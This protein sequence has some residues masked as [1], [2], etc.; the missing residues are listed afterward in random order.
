MIFAILC[1]IVYNNFITQK[2]WKILPFTVNF[3]RGGDYMVVPGVGFIVFAVALFATGAVE[4]VR[5]REAWRLPFIYGAM[6]TSAGIYLL[7]H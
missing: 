7:T 4:F 3:T 2:R 1:K 5:D 6:A